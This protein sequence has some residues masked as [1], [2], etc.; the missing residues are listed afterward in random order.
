MNFPELGGVSA[1]TFGDLRSITQR[2]NQRLVEQLARGCR[3]GRRVAERL[4]ERVS[5]LQEIL[6][7]KLHLFA[8]RVFPEWAGLCSNESPYIRFRCTC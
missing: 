4:E 6:L 3:L 1:R 5:C 7:G 2:N 8:G